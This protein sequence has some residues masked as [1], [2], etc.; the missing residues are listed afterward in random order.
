MGSFN[1][2]NE[3]DCRDKDDFGEG[4]TFKEWT[5]DNRDNKLFKDLQ[6]KDISKITNDDTVFVWDF[7]GVPFR[8]ASMVEEDYL[9]ATNVEDDT[10]HES[11]NVTEFWGVGKKVGVN[12]WVG[13]Q[14]IE[15]EIS[16]LPLWTKE[17]FT[18]EK[19]KRIKSKYINKNTGK[20]FKK[21]TDNIKDKKKVDQDITDVVEIMEARVREVKAQWGVKNFLMCIGSGE[22]FRDRLM[23]PQA[24][25]GQRSPLRP[26]LLKE[27]RQWVID[28]YPSEVAPP[29]FETDDVVE[30]YGA[31]SHAIYK[32][33]EIHSHV[34]I[35]EDKDLAGNPKLWVNYGRAEGRFKQPQATLIEDS[36]VSCGTLQLVQKSK[37]TEVK[38]TGLKWLVMQAFCI[39]DQSDNYH[40]YLKFDKKLREHIKY[41]QKEAY[42]EYSRLETGKEILQKAVDNMFMWFEKGIKYKSHTSK[43]MDIDTFQWMEICFSVAYMT[44][45]PKDPLTF[46]KLCDYFKVDYSRL[47][48]N[49]RP[50]ETSESEPTPSNLQSDVDEII[51]L[52]SDKS[53]KAADKRTRLEQGIEMLKQLKLIEEK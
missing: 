35:G 36:S 51:T 52:L 30:W 31:K 28:N 26:I 16:D 41:G 21:E 2:E 47:V 39:G 3:S 37:T 38:G 4:T 5:R 6:V 9:V 32:K 53:G 24:Y 33:T 12:S 44:K 46:K 29:L 50:E 10:T 13:V 18:I 48:D 25:K 42:K 7:D 17:S 1:I 14:N 43:E 15:R 49:N 22:V 45:S 40:G 27:A 8:A 19:K 23:L 20:R 11:K 34:I